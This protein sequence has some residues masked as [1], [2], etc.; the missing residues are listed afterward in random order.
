MRWLSSNT[1][2]ALHCLSKKQSLAQKQTL[3]QSRSR[4]QNAR[5]FNIVSVT[6]GPRMRD[7]S[8]HHVAVR[9]H[10]RR[11]QPHL[12]EV[13]GTEKPKKKPAAEESC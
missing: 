12:V 2:R 11:K 8:L 5:H 13:S 9:C 6:A 4:W 1:P 10:L 3:Q 7:S